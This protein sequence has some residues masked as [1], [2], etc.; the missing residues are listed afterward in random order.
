[1]K[2]MFDTMI[3]LLSTT[4]SIEKSSHLFGYIYELIDRKK[5]IAKEVIVIT[6]DR[7]NYSEQLN[8]KHIPLG[9][10]TFPYLMHILFVIKSLWTV[11]SH[12]KGKTLLYGENYFSGILLGILGKIF[13]APTIITLKY[14][15]TYWKLKEK[16]YFRFILLYVIEKITLKSIDGLICSTARMRTLAEKRGIKKE[17]TFI[18]PNHVDEQLF[19]PLDKEKSREKLKIPL[20]KKILF[21]HGRLIEQKNV[22]RVIEAFSIVESKNVL[23]YL[24]SKDTLNKRLIEYAKEK[25]VF[26]RINFLKRL[27]HEKVVLYLNS[28]DVYVHPT[29]Y[30][31][32]PKSVIEAMACSCCILTSDVEGNND[33]IENN[34][35]GL[36]ADHLSSKN[37]AKKIDYLLNS[38]ELR[39]KLGEKA[40]ESSMQYHKEIVREKEIEVFKRYL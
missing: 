19:R 9:L 18:V 25:G 2:K 11:K 32:H 35:N 36:F 12:I 31:G 17:K 20:D 13:S 39:K 23:L 37:I 34:V 1:M 33:V 4:T 10:P 21:Y 29:L 16:K 22:S 3:I 15:I 30:E 24:A 14:D 26:E 40:Y 5:Q 38:P 27:S 28:C 8:T 7:K 6:I